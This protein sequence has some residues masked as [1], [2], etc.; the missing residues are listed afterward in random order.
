MLFHRESAIKEKWPTSFKASHMGADTDVYILQLHFQW[1]TQSGGIQN[2]VGRGAASRVKEA[3][4]DS[5]AQ[6]GKE[7]LGNSEE[8]SR[9]I[10]FSYE[11]VEW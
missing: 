7:D 10:V 5:L 9:A 8:I 3:I 2:G 6:G 11:L 4:R 1:S